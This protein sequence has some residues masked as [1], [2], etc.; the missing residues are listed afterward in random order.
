MDLLIHLRPY[1][2]VHEARDLLGFPTICFQSDVLV[3]CMHH[4]STVSDRLLH[5]GHLPHDHVYLPACLQGVRRTSRRRQV[6]GYN[7]DQYRGSDLEWDN[8]LHRGDC[9]VQPPQLVTTVGYRKV[10]IRGF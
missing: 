5:A 3:P 8:R 4:R 9:R 1:R 6:F 7:L 2:S 10:Y